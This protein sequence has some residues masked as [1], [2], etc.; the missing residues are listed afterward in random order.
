MSGQILQVIPSTF[1]WIDVETLSLEWVWSQPGQGHQQWLGDTWADGPGDTIFQIDGRHTIGRNGKH[2]MTVTIVTSSQVK[3]K[4]INA[5]CLHRCGVEGVWRHSI[6]WSSGCRGDW[7]PPHQM[8]I[9]ICDRNTNG[10]V[11][12]YGVQDKEGD[13][14]ARLFT[15]Q[16][17][18]GTVGSTLG[19]TQNSKELECIQM[20]VIRKEDLEPSMVRKRWRFSLGSLLHR[21][22]NWV[23][24]I[25][26]WNSKILRLQNCLIDSIVFLHSAFY[27]AVFSPW[28]QS[29]KN[30]QTIFL[31]V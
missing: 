15:A 28:K 2:W 3:S 23:T 30:V 19:A 29:S 11:G 25:I 6:V 20:R 8:L 1:R 22:L 5:N 27:Q 31:R 24:C 13:R 21:G 10:L 14:F 4:Q 12:V 9:V 16:I 17:S 18:V 26:P 7:L